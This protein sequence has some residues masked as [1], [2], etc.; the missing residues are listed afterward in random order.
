MDC[1]K[2]F[3]PMDAL[4]FRRLT[5]NDKPL[6]AALFEKCF[7]H[8]PLKDLE[9]SWNYRSGSHSFGFWKGDLLI[10]FSIGSYHR[11]SGSS[12]YIDYFA[13][14]E[15]AR[16]NGLGTKILQAFLANFEGSIHLF[17]ISEALA[18][19][20]SR[21]GFRKSTKGYYVYNTYHLRSRK[22]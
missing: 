2:G 12:L 21:N 20:Y 16:G 14:E 5:S 22:R 9:T 11:Y 6:V 7:S 17:P 8:I 13:L 18:A 15:H 3:V 1:V 10:G 19:W 4:R